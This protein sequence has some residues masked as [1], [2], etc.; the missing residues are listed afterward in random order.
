MLAELR[1]TPVGARTTF[2]RC[3]A[4]LVPLLA[5]APIQYQVNA[6]GTTIEGELDAILELV[7]RA[8][9]ELRKQAERVLIELSLDDRS[10]AEGEIVRSIEH[11]KALSV[12]VPLERLVHGKA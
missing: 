3:V 2:A 10:C 7:R 6:M 11:V 8:H 12:D 4:H 5:E 9:G 1:I